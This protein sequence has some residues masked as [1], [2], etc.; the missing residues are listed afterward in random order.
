MRILS[1]V[2]LLLLFL[3]NIPSLAQ[4]A[5]GAAPTSA[6][7]T[8]SE[9][10]VFLGKLQKTVDETVASKH[11]EKL[12]MQLES[13]R[14]PEYQSWFPDTFGFENGSKLA[15]RYSE[16][17][18]KT[19]TR[20]VEYF[21][22]Q[23]ELGG[24][25][26]AR[27]VFG[28]SVQEKTKFGEAFNKAI[29]QSLTHPAQFYAL[30]YAGKSEKTGFPFVVTFG[31]VTPARGVFSLIN[32]S[33]LRALPGMP[34]A[35]IQVGGKLAG[36]MLYYKVAPK[37][38]KQARKNNVSGNVRLHAIIAADGTITSLELVSGDPLLA[39]AALEA[40]RQWRYHPTTLDGEAVEV[41]TTIDVTFSLK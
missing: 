8:D 27:L 1:T 36:G 15:I 10:Q 6:T 24:H 17:L 14:V 19:E 35:R 32:E 16:S 39:P 28:E 41:D 38:P 20:L 12:A 13:M 37:Y 23:G 11:G 9:L 26:T 40:V 4:E 34:A 2:L 30:E 29:Q 31:Y 21:V 25:V 22:T 7:Q 18:Q 3:L 5:P 33:V